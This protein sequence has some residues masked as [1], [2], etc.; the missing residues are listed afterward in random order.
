[1]QDN[2]PWQFWVPLAAIL[3]LVL[4]YM[5]LQNRRRIKQIESRPTSLSIFNKTTQRWEE[6]KPQELFD[7][8]EPNFEVRIDN[9]SDQQTRDMIYRETKNKISALRDSKKA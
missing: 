2:M 8:D 4:L 6:V 9:P 5:I 1:M 7:Q 3:W